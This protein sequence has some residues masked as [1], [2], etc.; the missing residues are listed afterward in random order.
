MKD[1]VVTQSI[2]TL[3]VVRIA[4]STA[5]TFTLVLAF[6]LFPI[7]NA[8][9]AALL[10]ILEVSFLST[11]RRGEAFVAAT[12]ATMG[13]G[14]FYL[15]PNGFRAGSLTHI[16]G[17]ACFLLTAM[18]IIEVTSRMRQHRVEA[19]TRGK[20]MEMLHKLGTAILDSEDPTAAR[21]SIPEYIVEMFGTEQ[22]ALY[23]QATGCV[24]RAG[25]R[26]ECSI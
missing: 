26:I 15:P 14:Y 24:C 23:D 12:I 5:L 21:E 7:V 11:W 20:E 10:L 13:F 22:A 1:S 19:N 2:L 17:L 6:T 18:A 25:D 16:V 4:L 3:R 9:A 8:M